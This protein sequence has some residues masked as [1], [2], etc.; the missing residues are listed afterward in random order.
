M[1][2][3]VTTKAARVSARVLEVLGETLVSSE[4]GE[5]APPQRRGGTTKPLLSP[6]RLT[7]SMRSHGTFPTAASTCHTL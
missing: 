7:I 3:M 1:E 6:L 5:G 4:P 2:A